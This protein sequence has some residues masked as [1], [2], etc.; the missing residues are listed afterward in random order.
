MNGHKYFRE[1]FSRPKNDKK[2][3]IDMPEIYAYECDACGFSLPCGWGGCM[4]VVNNQGERIACPHPGEFRMVKMITGYSPF[5]PSV[6]KGAIITGFNSHCVC[7]AC[8]SK[9]DLDVDQ[10]ERRCPECGSGEIYT[11]EE[12][13][14]KECPRCHKGIIEKVNTGAMS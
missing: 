5:D 8:L 4:Y 3:R 7:P 13:I 14:G 12:M 11:E 6:P 2:G 9:F 10:D 1:L